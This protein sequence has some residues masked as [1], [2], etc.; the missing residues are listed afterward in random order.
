MAGTIPIFMYTLTMFGPP[1]IH[2]PLVALDQN[3]HVSPMVV[4]STLPLAMHQT[5]S[6]AHTTMKSHMTCTTKTERLKFPKVIH[7]TGPALQNIRSAAISLC[8]YRSIFV[9][10]CCND[11]LELYFSK[12]TRKL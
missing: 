10:I 5:P 7:P 12:T 4:A 2:S 3:R 11:V 6:L 9:K 8:S 1:N